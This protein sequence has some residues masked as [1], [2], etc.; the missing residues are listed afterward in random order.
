MNQDKFNQ[1]CSALIATVTVLAGLMTFVQAKAAHHDQRAGRDSQ[2]YALQAFGL[3]VRGHAESNFAYNEAFK[4]YYGLY[5]LSNHASEMDQD[6]TSAVYQEAADQLTSH[7]RIFKDYFD[8]EAGSVDI[9][10]FEADLYVREVARLEQNFQSA[11]QV[12]VTWNTKATDHIVHLTFLAVSLFLL[13]QACS[14]KG[15]R[16]KKFMLGA[17]IL[18]TVATML[19]ALLVWAAPVHDLR[20]TGAIEFY[21]NGVALDH[22]GLRK[23][24]IAEYDQAIKAAPRYYEAYLA[25][26]LGQLAL[27]RYPEATAD[28][29]AG[30]KLSSR[31]PVL[32]AS[33]AE[34]YYEQGRFAEAMEFAGKAV[35]LEPDHVDYQAM[36][37]LA[38]L[39]SGEVEKGLSKYD[40]AMATA[41]K[42]VADARA[43]GSEPPAHIWETL[44]EASVDVEDLQ[45]AAEGGDGT[46]PKDKILRPKEVAEAADKLQQVI[47]GLSVSLEYSG[48]PPQGKLMAE[49]DNLGF[50]LPIYNDDGEVDAEIKEFPDDVFPAGTGEVVVEFSH[51]KVKDGQELVMRVFFDGEELPSW[52]LVDKWSLGAGDGETDYWYKI[53]SP[54]YSETA[55]LDAGRYFVEFFIDGH[56]ALQ[57]GFT[58]QEESD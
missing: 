43:A 14:L 17:G 26:G 36:L 6:V 51:A 24:A 9:L 4:T 3:K 35:A 8:S 58:V 42:S 20:D 16:T 2:R 23:E 40:T 52:R 12:K 32:A 11:A 34:A 22:R 37:A 56:L 48:K 46:P 19:W 7:S 38:T 1:L 44:D 21:A 45:S 49:L 29:E 18:L 30:W 28:F 50:G 27:E 13:G 39:A 15:D 31:T 57:G 54:G 55:E 41:S 47:D 10:K 5:G 53:L 25:R 33:L